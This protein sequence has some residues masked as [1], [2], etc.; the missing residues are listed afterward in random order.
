MPKPFAVSRPNAL[1]GVFI[2]SEWR[3][4]YTRYF[5]HLLCSGDMRGWRE[6]VVLAVT[7]SNRY[8]VWSGESGRVRYKINWLCFGGG[9]FLIHLQRKTSIG[10]PYMMG[11]VILWDCVILTRIWTHSCGCGHNCVLGMVGIPNFSRVTR[12]MFWGAFVPHFSFRP[13]NPLNET[14]KK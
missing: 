7:C 13:S 1:L 14:T 5:I 11:H 4:I 3:T 9:L 10:Y 12:Q 2:S 6:T 8:C